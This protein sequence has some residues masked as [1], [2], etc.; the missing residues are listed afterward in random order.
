VWVDAPLRVL[1]DLVPEVHKRKS[2]P[3]AISTDVEMLWKT[4]PQLGRL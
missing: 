2:A 3:N 4:I 1:Q